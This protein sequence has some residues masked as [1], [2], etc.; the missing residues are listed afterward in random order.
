MKITINLASRPYTDHGPAIKQLRIA[1]GVLAVLCLLFGLGLMH[2]HQAA[3]DMAAKEER[4]DRKVQQVQQ[5][6]TGYRQ[7][8]Q[9]PANARVLQ[10][11]Q[12]LNS[13]FDEKSFSWTGAMEDLEQVLPAGV[14]VTAIEPSRGKDG[15]ITLHLRVSGQREQTV[16][17]LRNMEHSKRFAT[18]R[19]SGENAENSSQGGLQQVRES[20]PQKVNFEV[21]AEYNPATLAERKAATEAMRKPHPNANLPHTRERQSAAHQPATGQPVPQRSQPEQVQPGSQPHPAQFGPGAL[22]RMNR[23]AEPGAEAPVPQENPQ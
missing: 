9:Q 19:I 3:L 6:Q 2:F 21:L 10:Q 13:L 14:Q 7:Q 16:A 4:L 20:G 22:P 17:M 11:A 23:P 15:R 8:M 1:M 12:F 18:P 5:E